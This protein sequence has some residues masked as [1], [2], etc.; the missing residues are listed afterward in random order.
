MVSVLWVFD[1]NQLINLFLAISLTEGYHTRDS[2]D[3][4]VSVYFAFVAV[5]CCMIYIVLL[6]LYY[7]IYILDN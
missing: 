5:S 6:L 7:I 2:S 4:S 3:S 1:G